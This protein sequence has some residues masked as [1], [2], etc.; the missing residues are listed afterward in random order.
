MPDY[1]REG[2]TFCVPNGA[3]K[4]E[5]TILVD[6]QPRKY[7]FAWQLASGPCS[8]LAFINT[9]SLVHG[10]LP[11][12]SFPPLEEG[13]NNKVWIE[14]FSL[15]YGGNIND[16]D[17]LRLSRQETLGKE[18]EKAEYLI[19]YL[20]TYPEGTMV[21]GLKMHCTVVQKVGNGYAIID[22]NNKQGLEIV[23]REE[24][25]SDIAGKLGK[26][27]EEDPGYRDSFFFP[28]H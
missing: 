10:Q 3:V 26:G 17:V 9:W 19:N 27:E 18:T 25:V 20:D 28:H 21:R 13:V 14:N 24:L 15:L 8:I 12:I 1:T 6:N 23:N 22:A 11:N 16:E 7:E 2:L 4:L 5:R